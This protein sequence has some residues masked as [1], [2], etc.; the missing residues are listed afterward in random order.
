[1]RIGF[2]L[3][4]L[5]L[6]SVAVT[7][8]SLNLQW[9][10]ARLPMKWERFVVGATCLTAL[11]AIVVWL[12]SRPARPTPRWLSGAAL[13]L[14]VLAGTI[15]LY[16]RHDALGSVDP[17]R[18]QG[19]GWLWLMI[20]TGLAVLVAAGSFTLRGPDAAPRGRPSGK[21]KRR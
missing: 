7:G 6:V 8:W 3:R 5:A 19:P 14:A 1:M 4:A 18:V 21:R 11:A 9:G 16:V 17:T 20:G 13:V 15:A 12:R 10:A 2:L